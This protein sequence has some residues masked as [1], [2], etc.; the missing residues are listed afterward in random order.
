MAENTEQ[1]T[2][3][4]DA[5]WQA[6]LDSLTRQDF[7]VE[8]TL[9][10][11]AIV[12]GWLL[13][14][15][16][17]H[18]ATRHL[19]RHP[20]RKL[21]QSFFL[22][23]LQLLPAFLVFFCLS[24]AKPF[25]QRY[26]HGGEWVSATMQVTL[27]LLVGQALIMVI[28]SRPVAYFFAFVIM[29]L[30][31]LDVSGFMVGTK[32]VLDSLDVKLGNVRLSMLGLVQGIIMLVLV[33]WIA[34]SMSRMLEHYLQKSSILAYNTRE[35]I[36]KFFK[37][38]VYFVAFIVT[39]G[40]MGIDLTAL[41][42]FGGALGVGIGL[43]LQ[44]ITANFVSGITL[45]IEKSIR[46]GDFI[47]VSNVSGWVRQLNIRYALIETRDGR[48]LLIPNEL[49]VSTQVTNWTHS[50]DH[51]R[52]EFK[53]GVAYDSD[54]EQVQKLIMEVIAESNTILHEPPPSCQLFE[55]G[56]FSLNLRVTFWVRDIREGRGRPQDEIMRAVLAKFR[57]NNIEIPYPMQ[58][59]KMLSEPTAQ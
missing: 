52:V 39:L 16:C 45:L 29:A 38:F 14:L 42:I 7:Y 49:L 12:L 24:L 34:S 17:R 28:K 6:L 43:G 36:V 50:N 30:T 47:E 59:M 21:D 8:M 22:R 55:F 19:E 11:S 40:A 5:T 58:V 1:L 51:A 4:F 44:K 23:P 48:E 53:V 56:D 2:E 26:A 3:T 32:A 13:S 20:P 25:A 54:I 37:I 27:A 31:L 33:F 15:I 18:Q 10:A 35:L 57:S 46:I 9:I 41:A